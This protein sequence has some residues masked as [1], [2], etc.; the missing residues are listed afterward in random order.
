MNNVLVNESDE[1]V[2]KLLHYFITERGYNPIVLHGAKNEI[3]L[4]N[5]DQDYKI[6]RIVSDYIHNNEQLDFDM[7][8][9]KQ[10]MKK[11]R[12][13]TLSF[14]IN[15]LSIFINL[16]DN[17]SLKTEEKSE[18]LTIVNV[19]S[20][21]DLD[22]YPTIIKIFPDICENTD[23]KEEGLNL[24]MKLTK[25][26]N[27]K[28]EE[29]SIKAEE[30]F[31]AKKPMVTYS[32]IIINILIFLAMYLFGNGS[33]DAYTLLK[34]GANFKILIKGGEYYR[35]LSSAFLHIGFLHLIFNNYALYVIGSQLESFLGKAKFLI[36]YIFSAVCGN[37]MSMIFSTGISAGASGAIF[38][39]LGA[40]LYF[41]YNYRVYLGSVI[42]SQIIPLIILNLGIGFITPGIDNAAHIGGLL[43]GLGITMALGLKHKTTNFERTNGWIVTLIYVGFLIFMG[44]F[45]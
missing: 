1:L 28:N 4:E 7:F 32:L 9:T 22:K 17:V 29:E 30:I 14:N 20:I 3:W 25:E 31:K 42:K 19:K 8:K 13:K 6:V 18:N 40:L 34:F 36:V 10:I 2:M 26:I 21:K 37:L 24:F 44:F 5:L 38:G 16:G 12:K 33:E 15:A 35:L 23:F 41:G 45:N 11:I 43:G 27:K 39:L